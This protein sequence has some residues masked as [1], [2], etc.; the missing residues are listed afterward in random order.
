M[1]RL[2]MA[3]STLLICYFVYGFYISQINIDI[4]PKK[5]KK[6]VVQDFYD[7]KGILN[8]HTEQSLGSSSYSQIISAARAAGLDFVFFTDLN[9]FD[10]PFELEGYHGDIFVFTAGKYSYLDSRLIHYSNNKES[11]GDNLGN[12]QVK[13]SDYLSQK[14]LSNKDQLLILAHPF[15]TGFTWSGDIPQGMDGIEIINLKSLSNRAWENSKLSVLW[16]LFMYP[17]NSKLSLVRLFQ[18]PT[19]ELNLIDNTNTKQSLNFF[20][21]A[22]AS[23]RA[24]PIANYLIKFPSYQKSFEIFSTHILLKSE[25]TGQ[26]SSDKQK[27]YQALKSGS[28]YL[29]FDLLGDPKGFQAQL[30]ENGKFYPMGSK[31][32]FSKNLILNAEVPAEPSDFYEIVVYRNGIRHATGNSSSI[33]LQITEPG[34]YRIQVRVSPFLPLPDGKKWLTWIYTNPFYVY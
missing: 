9:V 25:L 30:K 23:A 7:Y 1:N 11:L 16:S 24:I 4:I 2:L 26:V 12:V 20:A 34:T 29:A 17:F 22:E 21:G 13:L 27:I 33:N 18:E 14:N 10:V 3:F 6:D 28:F 8:V 5:L 32:K 15:K 31:V 19:E